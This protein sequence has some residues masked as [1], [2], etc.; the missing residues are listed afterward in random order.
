MSLKLER[1]SS[2]LYK[3]CV[4]G[5]LGSTAA[6]HEQENDTLRKPLSEQIG[7]LNKPTSL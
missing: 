6:A 2:I 7:K 4:L 5:E 1:Y 3:A